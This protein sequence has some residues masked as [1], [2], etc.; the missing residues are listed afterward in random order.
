MTVYSRLESI[1]MLERLRGSSGLFSA[2]VRVTRATRV[3]V[4]ALAPAAPVGRGAPE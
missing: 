4:S 2:S 3:D 1:D